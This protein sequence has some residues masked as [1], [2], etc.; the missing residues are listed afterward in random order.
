MREFHSYQ[1]AVSAADN[2]KTNAMAVKCA[3]MGIN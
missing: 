3:S 2:W 1:T